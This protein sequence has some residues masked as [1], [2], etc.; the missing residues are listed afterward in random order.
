MVAINLL[1]VPYI[2]HTKHTKY[3][4]KF[5]LVLVDGLTEVF[6][7]FSLSEEDVWVLVLEFPIATPLN[8]AISKQSIKLEGQ[9]RGF[10]GSLPV[11]IP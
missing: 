6:A 9:M 7:S 3:V 5:P 1:A 8:G 10:L 2:H 11:K 4:V